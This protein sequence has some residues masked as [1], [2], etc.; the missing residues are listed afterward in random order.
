VRFLRD[1]AS[2]RVM[3]DNEQGP[4]LWDRIRSLAERYGL[5]AYDSAYLELA[6]RS[7]LPLAT[8]DRDLHRAA[9]SASVRLIDV[10]TIE[11]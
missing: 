9:R 1:L 11:A 7:G 2:F 5:T 3:L 4:V 10:V 6:E 8:L